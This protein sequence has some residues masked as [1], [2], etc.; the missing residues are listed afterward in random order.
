MR[1][2]CIASNIQSKQY[3]WFVYENN[4]LWKYNQTP[5][6]FTAVELAGWYGERYSE[7]VNVPVID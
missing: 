3:E 7:E 6:S 5:L 4:R 2:H 1:T